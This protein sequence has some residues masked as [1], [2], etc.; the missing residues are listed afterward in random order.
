MAVP[1]SALTNVVIERDMPRGYTWAKFRNCWTGDLR[2]G[3]FMPPETNSRTGDMM[4]AAFF[5][6]II[7]Y[8]RDSGFHERDVKFTGADAEYMAIHQCDGNILRIDAEGHVS[9]KTIDT[10][11]GTIVKS[12]VFIKEGTVRV[13]EVCPQT[14]RSSSSMSLE[15]Y[16]N[17][18]M[19]EIEPPSN[20]LPEE[21]AAGIASADADQSVWPG[22]VEY[23]A[24]DD[25]DDAPF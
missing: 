21:A 19:R 7:V 17:K 22:L 2:E 25:L 6:T 15:E 5:S 14:E 8:D 18:M 3:R 12:I 9:T 1:A 11:N 20:V 10:S 23:N 4:P 24:D 16:A 13:L